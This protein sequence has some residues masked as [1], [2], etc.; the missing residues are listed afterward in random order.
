MM[1]A[2]GFTIAQMVEFVHAGVATATLEC[3]VAGS[4]TIEV[5]RVRITEAGGARW[6]VEH[7]RR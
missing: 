6:R 1:L 3:I 5:A 4:R 7:D 2:H